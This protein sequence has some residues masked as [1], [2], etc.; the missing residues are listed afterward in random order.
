MVEKIL[1]RL[2]IEMNIYDKSGIFGY[3]Q[4]LFAYNSNKIEGNKLN[5]RQIA[6]LFETGSL[7]SNDIIISKDIEETNGHFRMFNNMLS[8][9]KEKL[10]HKIINQYHYEFKCGVYQ[11]KLKGYIPGEYKKLSNIVSTISVSKTEDVYKDLD[12]LLN[13]YNNKKV[14]TLND[15]AIFHAKYEKIHPF[16]DGNGRTGR[17]II[18]KECLKNNITPLIISDNNKYTYYDSLYC[19]QTNNDYKDLIELFKYE[20]D[21]YLKNIK[22]FIN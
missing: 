20:Q 5:E 16:Q 22:D 11:D 7:L 10:S 6:S 18:F 14:I 21:N 15:I 3:T 4:R 1:R 2:L 13:E 19:A 17:I 12:M 8:N 9:Y